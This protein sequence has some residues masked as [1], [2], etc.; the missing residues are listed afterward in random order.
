MLRPEELTPSNF[1]NIEPLQVRPSDIDMLGHVN[2]GVYNNYL[3]VGKA[4]YF[5]A[6]PGRRDWRRLDIVLAHIDLTFVAPIHVTDHVAVATRTTWCGEKSFALDQMIFDV[7]TNAV[8]ATA[9]TVMVRIDTRT[10]KSAPLDE[11]WK[12]MLRDFEG[13]DLTRP[14]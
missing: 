8:K 9:E 13:R 4:A 7:R 10:E 1:S 14:L 12:Q 2:N 11:A 6:L 5:N 3:D